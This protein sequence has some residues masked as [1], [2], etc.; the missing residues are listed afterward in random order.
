[1]KTSQ[2]RAVASACASIATTIACDSPSVAA[3]PHELGVV[4]AAVLIAHLVGPGGEERAHVVLGADAAADREGD[5]DGI[6]RARDDVE[7]RPRALVRCGDVE[8]R[9]LV[10]A[11][12]VVAPACSTGSP[13]SRRPTKRTPLTTRPPCTSRHGMTRFASILS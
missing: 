7:Q 9:D 6:G 13:A 10:G 5:E 11:L 3:A 1:M 2:P 4:T 8:Q 12:P